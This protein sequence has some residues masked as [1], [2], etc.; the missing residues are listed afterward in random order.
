MSVEY[1]MGFGAG[2]VLIS[3]VLLVWYLLVTVKQITHKK[4]LLEGIDNKTHN[5]NRVVEDVTKKHP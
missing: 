4:R 5:I 1:L 2:F 3:L